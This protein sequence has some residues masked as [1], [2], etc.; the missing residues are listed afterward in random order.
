MMG[1]LIGRAGRIRRR[2]DRGKH[3]EGRRGHGVREKVTRIITK[4]RA[5]A[6]IVDMWSSVYTA[7]LLL[8][9]EGGRGQQQQSI[10]SSS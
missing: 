1:L 10:S 5:P 4:M 9:T 6:L 7:P 3:A 2:G 8:F